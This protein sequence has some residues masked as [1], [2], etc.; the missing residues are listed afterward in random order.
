MQSLGLFNDKQS[1]MKFENLGYNRLR[2]QKFEG[3][4]E[5]HLVCKSETVNPGSNMDEEECYG[6]MNDRRYNQSPTFLFYA[7]T[8]QPAQY[9]CLSML[10]HHS[11]H[12]KL[13][14]IKCQMWVK[15]G[16]CPIINNTTQFVKL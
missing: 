13:T 3:E 16:F 4:F 8:S 10:I 14:L 1:G 9:L 12:P 7:Y 2:K 11:Q 6:G 15:T 5:W